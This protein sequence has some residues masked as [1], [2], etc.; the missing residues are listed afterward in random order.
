LSLPPTSPGQK[1]KMFSATLVMNYSGAHEMPFNKIAIVAFILAIPMTAFAGDLATAPVIEQRG[2]EVYAVEGSV[3][4]VRQSVISPQVAGRIT[5]LTV[6]AGDTVQKGQLLVRIDAQAA[7]QQANASQAQVES[8]Q[9]QLNVATRE[10]ERQQQ[11]FRKQYISQAA[12]DQAEAQFKATAA[13]V[14][15]SV[16]QAGVA[17]TQTGFYS[18]VAPFSGTVAEVPS[19]LGDMAMP[20][21]PLLTV[22]DPSSMRV[23]A[24]LPQSKL[25]QL[26]AK[27]DVRLEIPGLPEDQRNI[28]AKGVTV[29]PTAD[30]ST[31]T[32]SVRLGLPATVTKALPGMFARA[33]FPVQGDARSRLVIPVKAVI[34]RTELEAVYVVDKGKALLRQVRLGKATGDTVEVLSGLAAG[35][36]VALDPV[37]ASRLR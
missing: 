28:I 20:G 2:G 25:G 18:I 14:R 16:A 17:S 31:H 6:K 29:L 37:A 34:Q 35:E 11:L 23:V 8:A 36:L 5:L 21:K 32:V 27:S 19:E 10:F 26:Q 4:A 22:F 15:G 30:P 24:N 12:L 7:A 13:A 3:E 33:Y 9:A 1:M